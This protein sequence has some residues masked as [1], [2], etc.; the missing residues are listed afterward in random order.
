MKSKKLVLLSLILCVFFCTAASAE[1]IALRLMAVNPANSEQRVP[2]K[3]Y[4]PVE[5]KP[6]DI[7]YKDDLEVGYDTQQGSYY[8]FGEYLLGPNEVLEKEIEIKDIWIID[9]VEIALL[10]Q[11]A[12]EVFNALKGTNYA[13]HAEMLYAGIE[14]KLKEA[15]MM[16]SLSDTSPGY[17]ISNYRNCLSLINSAKS[18]LLAAKTMVAENTPRGMVK[19]TWRL[20]VFVVIFLG[21]LGGGSFIIWQRQAKLESEQKPQE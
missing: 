8:V 10:H 21:I 4:L 12:K 1:E 15:E 16:Q 17:K 11:E 3:V 18:D 5:V 6:E 14:K 7:V 19:F 20:I 9:S 2:V 13:E